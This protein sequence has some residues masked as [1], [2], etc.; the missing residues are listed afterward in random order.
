MWYHVINPFITSIFLKHINLNNIWVNTLEYRMC[1]SNVISS[2]NKPVYYLNILKAY[3]TLTISGS[4]HKNIECVYV[5]WYYHVIN[6]FITSIFLKHINL[7]KIW[8]KEL[9]Y[10]MCLRNVISLCK[11]HVYY[12]YIHKAHFTL[13]I[14]RSKPSNI[15]SV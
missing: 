9:A 14:S 10:R 4:T 12:L 13:T 7:N 3:F 2:C 8:D 11:K 1:L 5:M 15:E 6:P